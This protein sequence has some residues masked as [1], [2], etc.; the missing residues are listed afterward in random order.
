MKTT[1]YF[2]FTHRPE[3]RS[4][5]G[6]HVLVPDLIQGLGGKRPVLFSDKGLTDAGLTQKIKSLFDMVPGIKLAGVF[7]DIQQ[8]AKSSN[9]NRGLK[10]FKECNGDSIIAIGG[11]SVLDTAKTVK[12]A[13]YNKVNQVEYVLTGNVLEVWPNAKPLGIPHISIPTTA[14]TGAEISSIS[15]VFNEMLNLKCNLMNPYLT[16]DIAV[17]DPDLTVGLPPRVTAFTGMDAL[18]HA[19]EGFFST[20]ATNFSDAFALHAAKIIVANLTT[21]VHEGKNVAARANMLQASAMAIT[22]FQSAMANIPIHNIAHTYGARYGIPHG[23][24]NAVLMPSVMKNLSGV[25]LPKINAFAPALGVVPNEANPQETLDE[26]I[27]VIVELRNAVNLPASFD[28][29]NIDAAEIP[30]LVPAVQ[31]DPS[32]LSFRIPE[33]VIVNVSQEVISSKVS[34]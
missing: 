24:A 23:L 25:Y 18:T 26:C 22:S 30:H 17:L 13:L 21:A 6:S 2:E 7:D 33:D 31:N 10:Y 19:V 20:K 34:I 3:I 29:F 15:V 4:G 1:S 9:I 12:W 32:S 27:N 5:A 11:G 28:E 8:D 14:G 16:S